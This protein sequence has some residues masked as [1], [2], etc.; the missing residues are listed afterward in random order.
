VGCELCELV[1]SLRKHGHV[2]DVGQHWTA[3]VRQSGDRPAIVL[4]VKEHRDGLHVLE[5][6]EAEE[7]GRVVT[8]TASVLMAQPG[9]ER[10]YSQSFNETQG[11]HVHF[12]L[13]PR[14]AGETALGPDLGHAEP[15]AGFDVEAALRSLT[16]VPPSGMFAAH[17]QSFLKWFRQLRVR[18]VDRHPYAVLRRAVADERFLRPLGRLA[19][20]GEL[21]VLLNLLVGLVLASLVAL[22]MRGEPSPA[23]SVLVIAL[24]APLLLRAMDIAAYQLGILLTDQKTPLQGYGRSLLLAMLNLVELGVITAGSLC[25]LG[26][27]PGEAVR[28]GA[29]ISTFQSDFDLGGAW[30]DVLAGMMMGAAFLVAICGVGLALGKLGETFY[31]A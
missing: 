16:L 8:K 11:G 7:L 26:L 9:V 12:H 6:A 14:F 18:S 23:R 13:I 30:M 10:V 1:S 2:I 25:A 20:P 15:P 29:R 31:K 3:N 22:S 28:Q 21:Y 24:V 17:V 27:R 19:D 5:P 4:Q